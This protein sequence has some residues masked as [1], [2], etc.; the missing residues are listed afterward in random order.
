MLIVHMLPGL[1]IWFWITSW[2]VLCYGRLFPPNLSIPYLS[3]VRYVE[4]RPSELHSIH[5]SFLLQANDAHSR[6]ILLAV[7]FL[8]LFLVPFNFIFPQCP[9][10]NL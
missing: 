5:I 3:V 6:Q 10:R 9:R 2:S 4:L 7:L 1:T 8:C